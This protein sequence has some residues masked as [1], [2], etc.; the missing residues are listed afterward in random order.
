MCLPHSA[1]LQ[2][3]HSPRPYNTIQYFYVN[4]SSPICWII[5]FQ[6]F[7]RLVNLTGQ[8]VLSITVIGLAE[9]WM[10]I[11]V[12]VFRPW[13]LPFIVG[14]GSLSSPPGPLEL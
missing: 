7:P 6:P 8:P 3:T 5:I 9:I 10:C 13:S 2:V 11:T 4:I 12:S 1:G 14:T